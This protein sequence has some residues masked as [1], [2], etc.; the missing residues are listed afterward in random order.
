MGQNSSDGTQPVSWIAGYAAV[1]AAIYAVDP[2]ASL[3]Q[4]RGWEEAADL[5]D[6]GDQ[7]RAAP[8]R[9]QDSD[10]RAQFVLQCQAWP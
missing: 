9:D 8:D 1:S 7:D 2:M 10:Q 5:E 3:P 6:L 4:T